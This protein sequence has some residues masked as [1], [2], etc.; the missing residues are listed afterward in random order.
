[1]IIPINFMSLPCG[2][3]CPAV[4]ILRMHKSKY[5]KKGFSS[6]TVEMNIRYLKELKEEETAYPYFRLI[7]VGP[8]LIHY[9]GVILTEDGELSAT[10][11]NMLVHIDMNVRKSSVMPKYL[12]E[13][14]G[15]MREEHAKTGELDFELRFL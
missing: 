13:H 11:E 15:K 1:M 14:L 5:F 7:D 10:T 8:K 12:L 4:S 9:G 3:L 2:L 6:F